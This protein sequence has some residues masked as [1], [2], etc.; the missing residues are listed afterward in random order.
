MVNRQTILGVVI[1]AFESAE[2]IDECLESLF[3]SNDAQL[4]VVVVDNASTDETCDVVRRWANGGTPFRVRA[5]SPLKDAATVPKPIGFVEA[6]A[7]RL[8]V[9]KKALTLLR[10]PINGGYAYAVN[11]GIRLL[12]RDLRISSFWV[13]NPDCVVP[14][15]TAAAIIAA[16]SDG[17]FSLMG[18][19]TL[20]YDRPDEIQSDGGLVSRLTGRCRSVN[21]GRAAITTPL[22][23]AASLDFI[24]GAHLVASKSY[25]ERAGLMTEDYFL[26][27]EEVDWAF[28][29]GSLPL[30]V[31]SDAIVYHHGGTSIGSQ[32]AVKKASPFANFFNFR[33]Q[34][35]F[36]RR[37]MPSRIM[38][39]LAF[40]IAKAMHLALLGAGAEAFAILAGILNLPPPP[41]VR[42]RIN[43]AAAQRL[44]FGANKNER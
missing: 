42:A 38:V 21:A 5:T 22:P 34:Q 40:G 16:A 32:S 36:V 11:L 31:A 12:A 24:S 43:G 19:R 10:S 23:S 44:A 28:R 39:A 3:N 13:L 6:V 8:D 33:N 37:F 26:Y 30:R 17:K 1:V 14:D 27:F 7:D 15:Y 18:G 9:E 4:R 25:I 20:H 41:P 29:R 2:I 35:R